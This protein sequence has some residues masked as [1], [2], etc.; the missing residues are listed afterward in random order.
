M[1]AQFIPLSIREHT[2]RRVEAALLRALDRC[3]DYGTTQ[4]LVTLADYLLKITEKRDEVLF[5][6][7]EDY[8]YYPPE[9]GK[10]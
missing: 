1:K 10:D 6:K 9:S 2:A 3:A 8:A 4:D 7:N 5:F